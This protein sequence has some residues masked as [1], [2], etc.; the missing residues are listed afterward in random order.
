M[1]GKGLLI[2]VPSDR[3]DTC[4]RHLGLTLNA[5]SRTRRSGWTT[6]VFMLLFWRHMVNVPLLRETYPNV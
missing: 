3:V 5:D 1:T 4:Q 6:R 2:L